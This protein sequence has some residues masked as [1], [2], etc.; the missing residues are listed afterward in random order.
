MPLSIPLTVLLGSIL[1][2]SIPSLQWLVL[3]RSGYCA[4]SWIPVNASAGAAGILWTL[5]PSPFIDE[6]TQ[7]PVLFGVF[8]LSG[9]LMTATVAALT[10]HAAH[11]LV[12][13][14]KMNHAPSG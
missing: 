2:L 11:R 8:L 4:A 12:L 13:A 3:R 7:G 10:G 5:A 9:P 14:S 6:D 1:L